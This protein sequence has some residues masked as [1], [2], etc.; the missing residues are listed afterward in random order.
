MTY[1][2]KVI[3]KF[4]RFVGN[5]IVKIGKVINLL[6]DRVLDNDLQN[7]F[8]VSSTKYDMVNEPDE[9]YYASQYWEIIK[10]YLPDSAEE[11]KCLD[12]GCGQGRFSFLIGEHYQNSLVIGCDLSSK[13][14]ENAINGA[15]LRNLKNVN[16]TKRSIKEEIEQHGPDS[17]DIVL[18]TEVAF[19]YPGWKS[20]VTQL[21]DKIRPGGL[22]II[23]LR[24]Q[25]FNSLILV[26]G[27]LFDSIPMLLNDRVGKLFG[28]SSAEFAWNTSIE[29]VKFLESTGLEIR[30]I[31]GIG[32]C[33][34]IPG[35]PHE[36]IARPSRLGSQSKQQL[37][38]LE[39][40]I[41]RTVPDAGRYIL[42]IASKPALK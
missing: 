19:F 7:F 5:A 11:L 20:D 35:D 39:L 3:F 10:P 22:L 21:V 28:Q 34:G 24:S 31:R 29:I 12:L 16:F 4:L 14:I 25:Y 8:V 27:L 38:N 36:G 2:R 15:V 6:A 13:A 42:A 40:E 26:K 1:L 23:S 30:E 9:P 41:G 18:M 17:L 37:M 32:A 33:S